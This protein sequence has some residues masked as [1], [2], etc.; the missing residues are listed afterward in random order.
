M[1]HDV[2]IHALLANLHRVVQNDL[3]SLI[4]IQNY[5]GTVLREYSCVQCWGMKLNQ[6]ISLTCGGNVASPQNDAYTW[7]QCHCCICEFMIRLVRS[8]SSHQLC[9]PGPVPQRQLETI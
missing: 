8:V 1:C 3:Q 9:P 4:Q 7:L 5:R 6:S 2:Y